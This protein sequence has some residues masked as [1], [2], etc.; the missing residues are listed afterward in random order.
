MGVLLEYIRWV[1]YFF[2]TWLL[3]KAFIYKLLKIGVKDWDSFIDKD[4]GNVAFFSTLK[5]IPPLTASEAE[6]KE[7][8]KS[9]WKYA[10]A[11]VV[12]FSI[13]VILDLLS[14]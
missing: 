11:S 5:L 1:A 14:P 7:W 3:L 4:K 6:R 9:W 2:S 8:E 13:F 10:I 12:S